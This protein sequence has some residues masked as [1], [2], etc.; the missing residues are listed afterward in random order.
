MLARLKV[1]L[2]WREIIARA[3]KE[4]VADDCLNLGAQQAYYFFFALFPAL[5]TLI[6]IASFFPVSNLVDETIRML[7]QFVPG[8]VLSIVNEQI[9]KISQSNH[10]GILTFA[11]LLTIWSSS[12]AVV[13]IITT[14]NAAYDITEG[15]PWWKVRLTAILLTIGIAF[16]IL[17]SISLV[18]VGPTVAEHVAESL[19]LGEAFKWT[20]WVLQWPVVFVLVASGVGMV[21]YLA[22]DAEQE[23]VWL[24]PGS[25]VATALWVLVSLGFKL[26][27]SFFGNYNETYG[28]IGAIIVLLTWLYLSGLAI[29]AGAELNSEIEHA[30][31]YGKSVGEKY[32][33]EK[34][35]LGI[36]AEKAFRER[37]ARGELPVAPFPDD[38]N[39]DLDRRA[40]ARSSNGLRASD[41]L[42]GAAA[43]LPAALRIGRE[44]RNVIG[45]RQ[46]D[47]AA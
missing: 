26:Y 33:G 19:R 40:N 29:L 37:Q 11:F 9:L 35:K 4:F 45:N 13:S 8:D 43:L 5:L 20:W 16:F 6:S 42:I 18:L 7:G 22:P 15:R 24:T 27:I 1:P 44:V 41:V 31:P 34:R 10:G 30:S 3:G 46:H 32:K 23:W 14:L 38:L 17:L 21:Y 2:S 25:I 12:G 47:R 28:T 36:A 39:C